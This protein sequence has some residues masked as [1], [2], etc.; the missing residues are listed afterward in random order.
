MSAARPA[1]WPSSERGPAGLMAAQVLSRAGRQVDVFERMPTAGRKFLMAGR[2]G[3]NLTHSEPF[4]RLLDR[5]GDAA[6]R[7]RP[8]L[9][10]FPPESLRA[11]AQDLGQPTFVGSSGRVF[12]E[13]FK[14][15][16]L[17]RAWLA[18]LTSQGVR[19]HVRH[20]WLGWTQDLG[21]RFATPGGLVHRP[22][23][24]A[25]LLAMGGAS[26]PQLGSD[27]AWTEAL[28]NAGVEVIPL[29]PANCGFE[30]RWSAVFQTRFAGCPIK[31]AVFSI[32]ARR[33]RGEAVVSRTGI[34]GAAIYALSAE[35]RTTIAREG[36][37]QLDIDLRPDSSEAALRTRLSVRRPGDSVSNWMRRAVGL[38][39]L[40]INL[41]R[42]AAPQATASPA[43]LAAAIKRLN[44]PVTRPAPLARA[45][46]TAGGVALAATD[47]GL[48]LLQ[49]PKRARRRRD[50]RLGS[51]N[52]RL[53]ASGL[54]RDRGRSCARHSA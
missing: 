5:Y 13:S 9:E 15:S 41:I 52:R 23:P 14:A 47:A 54:P 29:E 11:W 51:A 38:T 6:E 42:E 31:N 50:A 44:L 34:E 17:L 28:V 4:E 46:S 12:P 16:P 39:P 18:R 53:P 22:R 45:I 43:A 36:R 27:G 26:W 35:L 21:L 37:A 20:R 10:A 30:R 7:L 2:G 48:G 1:A 49:H 3:L 33:T 8:H 25:T 24:A 40:E 32:G 19:L